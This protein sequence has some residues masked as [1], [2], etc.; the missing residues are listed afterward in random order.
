MPDTLT[1]TQLFRFDEIAV[2]VKDKV[3]P[4]EAEV[5]RYVGLEHI[6]PESL[7]ICRWGETSDVESS[8]IL[9]RSGDIIFGKRRAYQRKLAVADFEGICS[10]HAMVL[11]PKTDVV[12]EEFLPFF[13]QSDIFM[14]RAV[15]ISVGGLS[16]TINWRD[17]AK[18]E[19]ALPPLEEQR[20]VVAILASVEQANL[21]TLTLIEQTCQVK[22]ALL[23]SL[24][25][26]GI[27]HTEFKKTMIGDIP[28]G[29]EV[30]RLRDIC[31]FKQGVQCPVDKQFHEHKSGLQRFIRIVDLTK[32][33]EPH[34]FIL[35]PGKE[36]HI[37]EQDLFMVRYGVPG[38]VGYGHRGVIA[39]NLF[40]LMP[41]IEIDQNY[42]Y[43]C[44]KSQS[45]YIASL[46]S[47]S[48]MPAINF[49][50]VGSIK[51]PLPPLP[52]Q[53]EIAAILSTVDKSIADGTERAKQLQQVKACLLQE[54]LTNKGACESLKPPNECTL[55]PGNHA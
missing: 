5:D 43:Q 33:N 47:S 30:K 40:R 14:D 52:E 26:K 10:A 15:K 48:T 39:N 17:L 36:H 34:R 53:R 55:P 4:E 1:Q 29:W 8:K 45:K 23:Q 22:E 2:Q 42:F 31:T 46:S 18:E 11:R 21:A 13:M 54:L 25:E 37:S 41:R 20:E 35:D 19:F 44:L 7:K 50:S 51:I 32:E 6:D 12:L 16:P 9:F 38:L 27:G 24:L 28:V 3:E 49:T